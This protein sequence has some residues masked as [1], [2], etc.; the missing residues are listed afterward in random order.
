MSPRRPYVRLPA[1]LVQALAKKGPHSPGLAYG[2]CAPLRQPWDL[3]T[4]I[5][6]VS[7]QNGPLLFFSN[8]VKGCIPVRGFSEKTGEIACQADEGRLVLLVAAPDMEPLGTTVSFSQSAHV[9]SSSKCLELT[10]ESVSYRTEGLWPHYN[11][12]VIVTSPDIEIDITVKC[13]SP[14]HW[15]SYAGSLYR[16]YSDIGRLQGSF[17]SGSLT[18][19]VNGYASLERGTGSTLRYLPGDPHIPLT[20]F[21]Y[22]LG[23]IADQGLFALGKVSLLRGKLDALNS[24]FFVTQ[25]GKRFSFTTWSLED[26]STT[27]IPDRYGGTI[28]VPTSWRVKASGPGIQLRYQSA[29][30]VKTFAG[31]GRLCSGCATITG[32]IDLAGAAHPLLG[33][34]IVYQEHLHF[35][36]VPWKT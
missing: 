9:I 16:H 1:M 13:E 18:I 5:C 7:S 3:R 30:H 26:V 8:L 6:P 20:F 14:L 36:L 17:R 12:K 34:G 4:I 25:Q 24:G 28:E 15:W 11:I 22:E 29:R 23:S 27:V 2:F 21:H 35:D 10:H 19:P 32:E 33:E 31:I